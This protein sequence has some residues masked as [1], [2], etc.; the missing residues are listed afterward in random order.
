MPPESSTAILRSGYLRLRAGWAAVRKAAAR[1]AKGG[2]R[3]FTRAVSAP[4]GLAARRQLSVA[5]I[6]RRNQS[7]LGH[8]VASNQ[9]RG[10]A[11][12]AAALLPVRR[13]GFEP[14]KKLST[15]ADSASAS[16]AALLPARREGFEPVKKLSTHADSDSASPAA[17]LLAR[18]E[19]FAFSGP[20]LISSRLRRRRPEYSRDPQ[21]RSGGAS[22]YPWSAR[23][24]SMPNLDSRSEI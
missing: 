9:I 23:R 2:R 21:T 22:F 12:S 1:K 8:N 15:H 13:E 6:R 5:A 11:T 7:T 10:S 20:A 4:P 18:R 24:P 19:G 14:V 3:I 17:L 16:P